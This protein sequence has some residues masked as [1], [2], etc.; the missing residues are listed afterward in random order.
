[1]RLVHGRINDRRCQKR[2]HMLP[3]FPCI[4][5]L[6]RPQIIFHARVAHTK[7]T[8]VTF[9]RPTTVSPSKILEF[10]YSENIMPFA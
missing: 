1:M 7:T 9:S 2:G 3:P 6:G 4:N 10:K 5:D 8:F